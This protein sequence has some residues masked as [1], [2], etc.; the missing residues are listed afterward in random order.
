MKTNTAVLHLK[1][2]DPQKT[3]NLAGR[4]YTNMLASSSVFPNSDPTMEEFNTEITKLDTA[5]KAKDGSKQKNQAV[6]DQTDVVYAMLKSL[7]FYVNKVAD[8]DKTIILLSG[9]DC[10]DEPTKHDKP[11]KALIKRVEDGSTACSVKIYLE[12]LVDADRYKVEIASSLGENTKWET[13]LDFGTLNKLEIKDLIRGK[14]IY[15]RVSG[16]NIYGWGTPSEPVVF[17]PR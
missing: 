4:V 1:S 12:P 3:Y 2:K 11:E 8:G 16:G 9:F 5:I 14:E 7:L 6:V 17:I 13:I 15:I 10:S